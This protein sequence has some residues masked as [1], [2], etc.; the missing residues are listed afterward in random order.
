MCIIEID[1]LIEIARTLHTNLN[2]VVREEI[3]V[4]SRASN[5]LMLKI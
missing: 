2:R 5:I 3:L 4:F 1:F